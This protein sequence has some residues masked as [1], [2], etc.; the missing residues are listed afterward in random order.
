MTTQAKPLPR[1]P[2][3]S[4]AVLGR[5]WAAALIAQLPLLGVFLL[6]WGRS[7]YEGGGETAA[8]VVWLA[9]AAGLVAA[10]VYVPEVCARAAPAG[11]DWLPGRARHAVARLRRDDRRAY[12]RAFGELVVLYAGAQALGGLVTVLHPYVRD[13]P[14]AVAGA[15]GHPWEFDY[16][17][18]AVQAVALYFGVCGATAWY[19]CR[20]RAQ[21]IAR[22]QES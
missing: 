14:A 22:H 19:A 16:G 2:V 7:R 4:A 21:V 11:P 8:A 15:G 18:F 17:A 10:V 3:P 13:A 1:F 20:L 12:L 6:P 5:T 9:L